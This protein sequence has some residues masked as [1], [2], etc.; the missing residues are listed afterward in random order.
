MTPKRA[1]FITIAS[2][3]LAAILFVAVIV[4]GS[5][6]L[7]KKSSDLVELKLQ[8]QLIEEQEVALV[9]ANKD[10]EKYQELE[11]ISKA[12][13]PQDKDQ[14]KT[15]RELITLAD[16][17]RIRIG[18]ISFP[19]STL[20]TKPAA[21]VTSSGAT[22]TTPKAAA[23][24]ISQVKPVEGINGLYQLEVTLSV[25]DVA[26]TF[27]QLIDFLERVE[28]NRRTAQVS[29]ISITPDATNNRVEFDLTMNVFV[30][31]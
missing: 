6:M 9:Q 22:T 27:N 4:L 20:G 11:T 25:R 19:D 16:Q 13:V 12:I 31:P 1:F 29:T 5:S 3:A 21:P 26:P 24:T 30:K 7:Q 14:A 23:P 8:Y 28:Q 18:S 2:L 10:I 17:S 15:V